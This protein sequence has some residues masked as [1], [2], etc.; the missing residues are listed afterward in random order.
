VG[1]EKA[2]EKGKEQLGRK[3]EGGRGR[4]NSI[5]QNLHM[6]RVPLVPEGSSGCIGTSCLNPRYFWKALEAIQK[7]L[8]EYT[9]SKCI[10]L[11]GR[12]NVK[13]LLSSGIIMLATSS[14]YNH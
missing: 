10:M 13:P 2:I 6:F 9:V 11:R 12:K 1:F 5:G 7:G 3:L 14:S 8:L 4:I